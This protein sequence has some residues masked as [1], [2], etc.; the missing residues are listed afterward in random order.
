MTSWPCVCLDGSEGK[1]SL[2]QGQH[3]PWDNDRVEQD[4]LQVGN[5][6]RPL[7]GEDA[8]YVKLIGWLEQHRDLRHRDLRHHRAGCLS[9][10]QMDDEACVVGPSRNP[11]LAS[12]RNLRRKRR[13]KTRHDCPALDVGTVATAMR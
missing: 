8:S 1:R 12:H 13:P 6:D 2:R 10:I 9:R 7:K 11:L 3:L 4:P 5:L